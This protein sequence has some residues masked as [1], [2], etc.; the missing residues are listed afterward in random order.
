MSALYLIEGRSEDGRR[1]R[2]VC[3][4]AA[5]GA[6]A[7]RRGERLAIKVETV[8]RVTDEDLTSLQFWRGQA[9]AAEDP[10]PAGMPEILSGERAEEAERLARQQP[11][12]GQH[13]STARHVLERFGLRFR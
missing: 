8:R 4:P 9:R 2:F 3:V 10:V 12:S 6:D 13:R 1:L 5:D 11:E 7:I